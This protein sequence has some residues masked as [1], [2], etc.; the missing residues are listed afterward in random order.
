MDGSAVR[1]DG[2]RWSEGLAAVTEAVQ[3]CARAVADLRAGPADPRAVRAA[4]ETAAALRDALGCLRYPAFDE[5]V[6][7]ARGERAAALVPPPRDRHG[8][9][10]VR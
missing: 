10:A 8:M 4:E 6:V 3:A 2:G 1:G 5:L 9:H 7:Q